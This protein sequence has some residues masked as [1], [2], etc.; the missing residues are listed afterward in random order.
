ME[1]LKFFTLLELELRPHGRSVRSQ[2][3]Y[4]RAYSTLKEKK[5]APGA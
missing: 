4:R 3:L 2:S 1:K 5:S